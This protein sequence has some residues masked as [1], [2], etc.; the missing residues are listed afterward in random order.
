MQF[1]AP[2]VYFP[3]LRGSYDVNP[4]LKLLGT[5]FGNGAAD[6]HA[7]QIDSE[8]TRF[9]ASKAR[10][11]ADAPERCVMESDLSDEV[12][13]AALRAMANRLVLEHPHW[14]SLVDAEL[15]SSLFESTIRLDQDPKANL[16]LLMRNVQEDVAIVAWDGVRDWT[17]YIHVCSPSHWAPESKI[18]NSFVQVHAPVP[19]FE[20]INPASAG[21][22][23]GM[24]HKGPF[25]R[26]VWTLTD[27]TELNHHPVHAKSPL[28]TSD[29]FWLRYERQVMIGLPEAN[30]ALFFIRVGFVSAAD[31]R[32]DPATMDALRTTLHGMSPEIRAYKGLQHGWDNL[33]QRI[34]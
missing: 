7:F 17:A 15:R 13:T 21:L 29:E 28:F 2:A 11:L 34:D 24:I 22:V 8:Y 30:A 31:I 20:K 32:K 10:S 19:G 6:G 1:P 27:D 4:N 18:G 25:V 26:F 23:Q 5:D 16:D 9:V 14:F 3:F 33:M 12:A